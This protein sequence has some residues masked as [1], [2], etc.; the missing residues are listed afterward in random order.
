MR[1]PF[2]ILAGY[3]GASLVKSRQKSIQNELRLQ[4]LASELWKI[5]KK[6]AE[7]YFLN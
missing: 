7:N 6:V 4:N 5:E 3:N 1:N 2:H